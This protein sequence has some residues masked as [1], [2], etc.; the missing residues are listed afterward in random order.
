MNFTQIITNIGAGIAALAAI[1]TI[2]AHLPFLPAKYAEF[3]ARIALYASNAKFSVNQRDTM[4]KD[5]KAE[6]MF[7]SD[8]P[9]P[10]N[11]SGMGVLLIAVCFAHYV[12]ACAGFKP[13]PKTI[14]TAAVI[15]CDTFFSKQ[16]PGLSLDDVEKAFCATAEQIQPFLSSAKVAAERGGAVRLQ[17][18][19]QP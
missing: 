10:P 17:R 15:L 1:A 7:P 13:S 5:P 8:P 19:E 18:S 9:L 12:T 11:L 16:K 3:F 4:P 6:R 2:L 14:D